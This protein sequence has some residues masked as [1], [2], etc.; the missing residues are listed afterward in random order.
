MFA[1]RDVTSEQRSASEG[2]SVK[3]LVVYYSRTGN[4]RLIGNEM[5]AALGADVEELKDGK[6]R[7]GPIGFLLSGM[8]A[9]RKITVQFEALTHNPADYDVVV[10][11][12][13]VWANDMCSPIRT[14]LA[15]H[16]TALNNVAWFCTSGSI[17]P[18]YAARGFAAMTEETGLTPVAT[19]GMGRVEIKREHARALS[20]FADKITSQCPAR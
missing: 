20:E 3:T 19:L 4:T 5:A 14:F 17:D 1:A 6:N 18:K 2:E 9:K 12:S 10:V 15:Q 7:A 16:K 13:P 8:E 11:G